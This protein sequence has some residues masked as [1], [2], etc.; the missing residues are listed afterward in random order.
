MK[1]PWIQQG[2]VRVRTHDMVVFEVDYIPARHVVTG[3]GF[4]YWTP[5]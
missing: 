5:A 1:R 3:L 4:A 2:L